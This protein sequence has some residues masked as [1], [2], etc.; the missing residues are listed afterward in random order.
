MQEK[1]DQK[2]ERIVHYLK[3]YD[4][5]G[6]FPFEKVRVDITLSQEALDKLKGKNK[7]KVINELITTN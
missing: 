6:K 1:I 3:Y 5:H 7:S 4:E 2:I